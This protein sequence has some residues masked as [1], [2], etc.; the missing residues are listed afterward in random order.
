MATKKA[1]P[2][3][4][5][6]RKLFA[7]R[8]KAGEFSRS[9]RESK[10]AK[11]DRAHTKRLVKR[12]VATEKAPSGYFANPVKHSYSHLFKFIVEAKSNKTQKWDF[13]AGFAEKKNAIQYAKSWSAAYPSYSVRVEG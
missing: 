6:A 9:P 3:Q 11:A 7:A 10:R 8:A 2:A 5:A 1:S 13:L 12:R 4:I